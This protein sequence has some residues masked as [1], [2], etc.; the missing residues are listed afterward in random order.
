[1]LKARIANQI[2]PV[3]ALN[4]RRTLD[5]VHQPTCNANFPLQDIVNV[6]PLELEEARESPGVPTRQN[7][8]CN[9]RSA[10]DPG[11]TTP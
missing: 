8:P 9:S 3:A 2:V 10:P 7:S 6:A 11:T 4:N 5:G 1:M